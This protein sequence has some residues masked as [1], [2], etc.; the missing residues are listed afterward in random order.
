DRGG[1]TD[2]IFSEHGHDGAYPPPP[3]VYR[4]P[5]GPNGGSYTTTTTYA[6]GGYAAGGYWYP[7]ATTTTVVVQSAPIVT[8][9]TTEY[10]DVVK[11]RAVRT[12]HAPVKRWHRHVRY[13][14]PA[15]APIRGS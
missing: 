9:T 4:G 10:V 14:P 5:A 8:T 6:G 11:T 2:Y 3:M 1:H 12:W 7:P 15:E 13:C